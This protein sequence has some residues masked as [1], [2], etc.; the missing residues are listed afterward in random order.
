MIT[1]IVLSLLS[2]G[3]IGFI[4]FKYR[5]IQPP[6][7]PERIVLKDWLHPRVKTMV[8][9][10]V[11]KARAFAEAGTLVA[12]K[13]FYSYILIAI[14]RTV[15]IIEKVARDAEKRLVSVLNTIRGKG[16]I[17]TNRGSASMFL[18]N[19]SSTPKQSTND[20]S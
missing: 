13:H 20:L 18:Q 16:T 11:E 8:R 4:V 10:H 17:P 6:V 5:N 15:P 19:I 7:A 14:N 9:P 1:L 12:K 2:L 3:S